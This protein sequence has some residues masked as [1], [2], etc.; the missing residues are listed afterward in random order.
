[1]TILLSL[2]SHE[3]RAVDGEGG[4]DD[5]DSEFENIPQHGLCAYGTPRAGNDHAHEIADYDEDGEAEYDC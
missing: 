2:L 3:K 4:H 1:M 5:G